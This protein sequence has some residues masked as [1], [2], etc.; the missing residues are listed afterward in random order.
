MLIKLYRCLPVDR[1]RQGTQEEGIG[2]GNE[3]TLGGDGDAHYLDRNGGFTGSH[4]LP[5]LS[6]RMLSVCALP[7][8]NCFQVI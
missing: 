4:I 8:W 1:G 5:K 6:G 7:Q 2:K 3:E